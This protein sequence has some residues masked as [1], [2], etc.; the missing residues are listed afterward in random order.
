MR[1]T[2]LARDTVQYTR[3]VQGEP[4]GESHYQCLANNLP[5]DP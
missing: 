3:K 4:N 5:H 1:T 2:A